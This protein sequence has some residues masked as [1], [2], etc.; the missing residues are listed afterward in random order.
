MAVGGFGL[1]REA[2]GVVEGGDGGAKLGE[3]FAGDDIAYEAG[4]GSE[5]FG[6]PVPEGGVVGDKLGGDGGGLVVE[7]E[8]EPVGG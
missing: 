8:D 2:A 4:I 1:T 5:A 3:G 7:F 6:I